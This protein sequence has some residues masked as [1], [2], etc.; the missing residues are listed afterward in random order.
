VF[1]SSGNTIARAYE[2]YKRSGVVYGRV[3]FNTK[4]LSQ[5][6]DSEIAGTVIHE[7]GHTLGFGWDAWMALFD[8]ETGVFTDDAIAQ[9]AALEK[10]RVETD[11][12][13]GTEYAH[14]DEETF[15]EELMTGFKDRSEHVLPV[16]IST[17]ELLGHQV[18]EELPKKTDLNTLMA[19]LAQVVFSRQGEA[20]ALDLDHFEETK[21]WENIPHDEPISKQRR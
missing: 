21:V 18:I 2:P 13:P 20:K 5:Y 16:T 17:M 19:A 6:T 11:Y 15:G 12:G 8:R 3:E 10:M 9:L 4:Y 1:T 14:W 7:I